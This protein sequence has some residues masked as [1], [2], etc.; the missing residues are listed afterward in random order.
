M[1]NSEKPIDFTILLN[2]NLDIT[3]R[4]LEAVKNCRVIAAD[5]GMYHAD[6][7]GIIPELWVGDFDSTSPELIQKWSSVKRIV[8][9]A[10]KD[11]TD[12]EIAVYKALQS[13]AQ[14]IMLAGALFGQRFDCALQHVTLA[15][16]LKSQGINVTL[17]SGTEEAFVL[18]PGKYDFDLPAGSAFSI[19]TLSDI[20]GLAISGALYVVSDFSVPL[21]SSRTL[22][23][24]V[25][26]NLTI[27][28][29]QGIGLLIARPY[30]LQGLN[31]SGLSNSKT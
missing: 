17:S 27:S 9:P 7:L 30:N 5:G 11:S 3:N 14:H 6:K 12:G 31:S 21:G 15:V 16:S 20:K 13:G 18:T 25:Q 19:V 2:G 8:Y 28:L 24:V 22:S 4:L 23:N 26:K 1:S 29:D 10:D